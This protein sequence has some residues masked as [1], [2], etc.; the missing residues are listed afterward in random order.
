MENTIQFRV[1]SS[2]NIVYN[3]LSSFNVSYK[4]LRCY[5]HIEVIINLHFQLVHQTL[6]KHRTFQMKHYKFL[7]FVQIWR[8]LMLQIKL[9]LKIISSWMIWHF[10]YTYIYI[11]PLCLMLQMYD[12][13]FLIFDFMINISVLPCYRIRSLSP[14]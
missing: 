5:L 4:S 9:I 2:L 3:M 10:M 14:L 7:K 11:Y 8:D 12:Y 1:A 13:N 6:T